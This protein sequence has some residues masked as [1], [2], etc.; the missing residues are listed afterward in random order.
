M[1]LKQPFMQIKYII[2]NISELETTLESISKTFGNKQFDI[3]KSRYKDSLKSYIKELNQNLYAFIEYPYNDRLYR[4]TYYSYYSTINRRISRDCI[5]ISL[6]NIKLTRDHFIN[7]ELKKELLHED[8]FLGYLVVRPTDIKRVGRCFVNPKA[9]I[10][11]NFIYCK[12]TID[13]LVY[14]IHFRTSGFPHSAQDGKV[15]TCAETSI[16]CLMEYFGEKYSYF[17]TALPSTILSVL[18][19]VS[20][21]RQLPSIGLSIHQMGYVLRKFGFGSKVYTKARYKERLDYIIND[22][23][24]SGIPLIIIIKG[25]N[26]RHAYLMVGHETIDYKNNINYSQSPEIIQ[27]ENKTKGY[28]NIKIT[29]SLDL[30]NKRFVIM[31]DNHPPYQMATLK[32]PCGY[33]EYMESYEIDG[34]VVPLYPKIYLDSVSARK[35]FYELLKNK[36]FG[37]N[38]GGVAKNQIITRLLLTSSRS[39]KK[40]INQDDAIPYLLKRFILSHVMPKFIWIAEISEKELFEQGKGLGFMVLDSTSSENDNFDNSLLFIFYCDRIIIKEHE[41]EDFKVIPIKQDFFNLYVNNLK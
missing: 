3:N 23:I 30:Y 24:E 34:V 36:H 41:T 29:D 40:V 7:P 37:Y 5:R 25:E 18:K 13:A 22:Y 33:S 26:S 10:N 9:Y 8:V 27:L 17:K 31:D 1:N 32:S 19:K 11:N 12:G 20:Y 6:F 38:L 2:C 4:D 14:G 16:W 39:F 21:E 28:R 15:H 35:L